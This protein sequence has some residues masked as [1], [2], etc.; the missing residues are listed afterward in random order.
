[1]TVHDTP[2]GSAR[3]F[4]KRTMRLDTLIRDVKGLSPVAPNLWRVWG[5]RTIDPALRER[6]MVAVAEVNECRFCSYAHHAWAV[7]AGADT[8]GDAREAI[9]VGWAQLFAAA[10]LGPVPD[11]VDREFR[12]TFGESER[13]DIEVVVRAMRLANLTANTADCVLARVQGAHVPDG[14]VAEELL[15]SAF[16]IP[17]LALGIGITAAVQRRSP[18]AVW[19]SL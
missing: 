8:P 5:R 12:L 9:A 18:L 10:D 11:D 7:A 6:I 1:M 19:Q 4:R 3:G 14:K 16:A 2:A 13:L 15:V 17:A